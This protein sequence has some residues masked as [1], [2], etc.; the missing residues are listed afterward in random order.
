[1]Q[2]SVTL[3]VMHSRLQTEEN[4]NVLRIYGFEGEPG[5][6]GVGRRLALRQPQLVRPVVGPRVAV[7]VRLLSEVVL[8]LRVVVPAAQGGKPAPATMVPLVR[9]AGMALSLVRRR[10]GESA[11]K[12][13]IAG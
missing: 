10:G 8:V 3:P 4:E 5:R 11:N 6:Q 7:V 12:G 1:M 9:R 13:P 2:V